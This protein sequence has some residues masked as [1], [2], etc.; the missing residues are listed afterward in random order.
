MEQTIEG[1]LCVVAKTGGIKIDEGDWINPAVSQKDKVLENLDKLQAIRGQHVVVTLEAEGIYTE[2]N[3]MKGTEKAHKQAN[4]KALGEARQ[5]TTT[6]EVANKQAEIRP[7]RALSQDTVPK[8]EISVEEAKRRVDQVNAFISTQMVDK[9]DYG[10]IDG[11]GNKPTLFKPGA[12]KFETI[13]G[14]YHEFEELDK[15]IE[16]EDGWVMFRYRCVVYNKKT[17]LKH[18]ECIGSA[19]SKEPRQ[20]R[21]DGSYKDIYMSINTIDKMAQKRAFVGAILSACS[22]SN[23][24]TQDIEDMKG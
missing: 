2:I 19:N 8:F 14:L 12:E 3:A 7:E 5:P 1:T 15:I 4:S 20:K 24:F 11:F 22:L 10:T 16:P 18:S 9:K 23:K 13:Y 21:K 6:G 17:G